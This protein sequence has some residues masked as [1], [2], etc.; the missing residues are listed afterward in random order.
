VLNALVDAASSLQLL[1][2]QTQ[3]ERN[4]EKQTSSAQASTFFS[5]LF[6]SEKRKASSSAQASTPLRN[7]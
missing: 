5:P 7:V 1:Q 2:V 4:K 3:L 6:L